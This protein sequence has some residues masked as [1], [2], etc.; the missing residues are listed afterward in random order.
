MRTLIITAVTVLG[1]DQA[2]KFLIKSTMKL[3][4]SI[5]VI[6]GFL[7][8]TYIENSGVSYGMLGDVDH[9]AKRWVLLVI[10]AIAMAA[11]LTYWYKYRSPKFLYNFSCGLI[12]GGALG[13]FVDRL[14][15]GSITDFIEVYHNSWHFPVF[16]VADSAISVGVVFFILFM[17]IYGEEKNASHNS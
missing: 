3:Y 15:I 11:I 10:V 7:N 9:P 5:P 1:V 12:I 4:Q 6:K 8:I 16:N 17:I 14:L 2:V 13:N